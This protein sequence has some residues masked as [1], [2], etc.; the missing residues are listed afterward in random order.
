MGGR[1]KVEGCAAPSWT[2]WLAVERYC[3]RRFLSLSLDFLWLHFVRH[4]HGRQILDAAALV[5]LLVVRATDARPAACG[6]FRR[7][8][9]PPVGSGSGGSGRQPRGGGAQGGLRPRGGVMV[10]RP[11]SEPES[12]TPRTPLQ[13]QG[14]HSRQGDDGCLLAVT[15]LSAGHSRGGARPC[16]LLK[17]LDASAR[18]RW[19]RAR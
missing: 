13:S 8:R 10:I 17:L 5:P 7:R 2:W 11:G 12:R 9:E 1:E 6:C 18:P 3:F 19:S 16:S 15:H 4:P 14:G